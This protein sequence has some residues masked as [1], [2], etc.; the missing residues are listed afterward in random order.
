FQHPDA[1]AQLRGELEVLVL[2]G[3]PERL[4]EL[5]Q[6]EPRVGGA[7]RARRRVALAHVLAGA[8]QPAQQVPQV[9]RER[10]VTLRAPQPT[11]LAKVLEGA[12][13]GG[14]AQAIGRGGQDVPALADHPLQEAAERRLEHRRAGLDALLLRTLLAQVE[15][16]L[17]V[18]LHLRQV[19]DR[20]A[21][22]AVVAQHQGIASTEPTAA[23]RPSSS[24]RIRSARPASCRLWVTTTTAVSYSRASRKNTSCS[25][26]ELAWSRLPEGSSASTRLGSC[27][28]ARAT[29]QRCCS[30]PDNSAG[31]CVIRPASPTMATNPPRWISSSTARSTSSGCPSPPANTLRTP[32]ASSSAV[33]RTESR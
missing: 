17:G 9:R 1:V 19:D 20:V 7:L 33:I 27:T 15:R 6:L 24:I 31:R 29:A 8:V 5:Q 25:R 4:L 22:L 14:A 26:S 13:A 3:R 23:R 11:R 21:L 10:V 28:S 16:D 2:D 30:P 18:V 32:R 12:P